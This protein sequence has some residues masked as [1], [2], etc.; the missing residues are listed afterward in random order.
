MLAEERGSQILSSGY[1]NGQ[2]VPQS[3]NIAECLAA[4]DK[5]STAFS[6]QNYAVSLQQMK[7]SYQLGCK[8]AAN[9]IG[10]YYEFGDGIPRNAQTA[11]QWYKTCAVTGDEDCNQRYN[12]LSNK[13]RATGSSCPPT[14]FFN[15][16]PDFVNFCTS[17]PGC[18]YRFGEVLGLGDLY[19]VK[20]ARHHR[21]NK[22]WLFW[23]HV[24]SRIGSPGQSCPEPL[25]GDLCPKLTSLRA[26]SLR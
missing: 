17:H 18:P 2:Y 25:G 1:H 23:S 21:C 26:L 15:K 14:P 13:L 4:Y 9:A 12:N 19:Y 3:K 20:A 16:N 22:A 7:G 6:T 11:L 5:G 8:W 10:V 24:C